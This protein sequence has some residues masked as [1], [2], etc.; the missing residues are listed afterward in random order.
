MTVNQGGV[1]ISNGDINYYGNNRVDESLSLDSAKQIGL[2]LGNSLS[3]SA[4]PVRD[5]ARRGFQVLFT[6]L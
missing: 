6:R 5:E 1:T 4:K 3:D 2:G